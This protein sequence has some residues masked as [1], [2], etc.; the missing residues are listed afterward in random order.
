MLIPLPSVLVRDLFLWRRP[1]RR[2]PRATIASLMRAIDME[3]PPL[4]LP[5]GDHMLEMVEQIYAR[6]IESLCKG[7]ALSV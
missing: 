2:D 7:A 6:R 1:S 4:H 5:M 3:H